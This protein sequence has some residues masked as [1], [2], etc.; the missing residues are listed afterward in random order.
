MKYVTY[1]IIIDRVLSL[2]VASNALACAQA[3]LCHLLSLT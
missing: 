2:D 1:D 3:L